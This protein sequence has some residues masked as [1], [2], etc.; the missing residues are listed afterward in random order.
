MSGR[1]AD[2]E[3][4]PSDPATFY[5]AYASGGLWKTTSN[6]TAFTPLLDTYPVM[7][8]GDVAVD[9][10][11]PEGDGETIW[12]GT[13][14]SNS[15]RSSY[16]GDGVYLSRGGGRV[17]RHRGLGDTRHVGRILGHPDDPET[18]FVAAVGHLYS[19]N[20]ERGV[21]RT[22]DDGATWEKV[23]YVDENT[24]AIDLVMDP[25]N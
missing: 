18:V 3:A 12:L 19:P 21:F 7:T 5:V 20:E 13:G 25:S 16:A 1:V 8:I 14:E 17:R 9:W 4:S 2:L 10:R 11:D 23:L 22:T 24:G 6:G 15:S